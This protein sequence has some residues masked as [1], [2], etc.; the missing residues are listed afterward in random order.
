MTIVGEYGV[1]QYASPSVERLLG[2]EPR[3]LLERNAFDFVHPDDISLV[4]EALARAI[5]HPN[6]PHSTEFRFRHR[7]GSWRVLETIGQARVD[8]R[9]T[10]QLIV[11]ARHD[12]ERRRQER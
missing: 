8:D 6:V 1:F 10:A 12:S 9:G 5:Q 7:D 11:N 4:A 2:Y 3:E